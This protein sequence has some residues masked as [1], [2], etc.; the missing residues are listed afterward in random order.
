MS[1][2][3]QT[4]APLHQQETTDTNKQKPAEEPQVHKENETTQNPNPTVEVPKEVRQEKSE[5][6]NSTSETEK[7][8]PKSENPIPTPTQEPLKETK[9]EN[10]EKTNSTSET[11]KP[12]EIPFEV[13]KKKPSDITIPITASLT[14]AAATDSVEETKSAPVTPAEPSKD[15]AWIEEFNK[16][17]ST[18]DDANKL[19][20]NVTQFAQKIKQKKAQIREINQSLRSALADHARFSQGFILAQ[21]KL[22]M[23]QTDIKA[24]EPKYLSELHFVSILSFIKGCPVTVA[25]LRTTSPA[26]ESE[27]SLLLAISTTF[28]VAVI[29]ENSDNIK[30]LV[31]SSIARCLVIQL[32]DDDPSPEVLTKFL[33]N[34]EL[35]FIQRRS[36]TFQLIARRC[37][38]QREKADEL[39]SILRILEEN[40][41]PYDFHK[42]L[43]ALFHDLLLE[44]PQPEYMVDSALREDMIRHSAFNG[45]MTL[46]LYTVLQLSRPKLN[47]T[48]EST[49]APSGPAKKQTSTSGE[50]GSQKPQGGNRNRYNPRGAN[51]KKVWAPVAKK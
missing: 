20:S 19:H 25:Y 33:E 4:V 31:I 3:Q 48:K 14:A 8:E 32:V 37:N 51:Q 46:A 34:Q 11:E 28:G 18:P 7:Q 49:G 27:L 6:K 2:E 12:T 47:R 45:W 35:K 21:I 1:Q 43:E 30:I 13:E 36:I 10:A 16:Y 42:S 9:Q 29:P 17:F 15:Q 26:L 23:G 24:F 22:A 40:E 5:Q 41:L 44:D 39:P 50:G 38:V